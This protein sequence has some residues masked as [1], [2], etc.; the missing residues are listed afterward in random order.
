MVKKRIF[1]K[2]LILLLL[3]YL[4]SGV[5]TAKGLRVWAGNEQERSWMEKAAKRY[6]KETGVK[7]E[8][9]VICELEQLEK[10]RLEGI[11]NNKIDVVGWP[12][13]DI[14]KA[15]SEGLLTPIE[16][17]ISREYIRDNFTDKSIRALTYQQDI[18]GLPYSYEALA[19][20]YNKDRYDKI[21][22]T[23]EEFIE[24]AKSK[25]NRKQQQYGFLFYHSNL[26]YAA[27][28]LL[29]HGG[30]V[31]GKNE[32]GGYNINDI[33]FN[34]PGAIKGAKLIKRF[35][36]EGLVP[37]NIQKKQVVNLFA[38]GKAG[39][40]LVGPWRRNRFKKAGIDFAVSP[41]PK[42]SNGQYP[43][44]FVGVKGFYIPQKSDNKE[45]AADFIKFITNEKWSMKHYEMVGAIVP[46]E[47][48]INSPKVKNDKLSR[49]FLIQ[50]QQGVLMPNILQM[51]L[52]WNPVNKTLDFLL[53]GRI[54]AEKAM[55]M[56]NKMI[57]RNIQLISN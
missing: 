5:V 33:G 30:Y 34:S 47:K 18:Y 26:Y 49:G 51:S 53:D 13:D 32:T 54:S 35:K 2:L 3:V 21:P 37:K 19:L 17:Y 38:E 46:H 41:I 39:A 50:A 56:T 31:F 43:K 10:L 28:F 42:L 11:A 25:T 48:V 4:G 55:A 1:I 40:I 24:V 27:P 12:H 7:V 23:M 14:G 20:V 22:E 45:L 16:N 8:L 36:D 44:P 57:T 9:E 15:V 52:V 29:G 6:E